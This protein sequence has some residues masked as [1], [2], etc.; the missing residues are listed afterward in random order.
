MSIFV[1]SP[2]PTNVSLPLQPVACTWS[3]AGPLS[4][5]LQHVGAGGR[6]LAGL[7]GGFLEVGDQVVSVFF[8]LQAAEG[9][10]GAGDVFLGVLEVG[11]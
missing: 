7:C 9:H 6:G 2:R 4:T 10:F 11:E 3:P 1:P 8:L 5:L